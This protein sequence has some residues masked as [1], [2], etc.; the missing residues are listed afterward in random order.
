[1]KIDSITPGCVILHP[2]TIEETGV[3][4]WLS[5]R[6]LGQHVSLDFV[7]HY[8]GDGKTLY[9]AFWIRKEG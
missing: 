5:V 6:F 7:T 3:M 2:E 9:P 4:Q 8:I 1:M